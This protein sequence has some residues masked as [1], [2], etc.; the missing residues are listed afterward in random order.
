MAQERFNP[1]REPVFFP[2]TFSILAVLNLT[3]YLL[4]GIITIFPIKYILFVHEVFASFLILVH[5][6]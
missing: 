2:A 6:F 3:H 5:G 1:K 4:S